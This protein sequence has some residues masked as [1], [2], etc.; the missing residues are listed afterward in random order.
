MGLVVATTIGLIVWI[1][2]WSLG[3]KGVD[4]FMITVVIVILAATARMLA[5]YLPGNRDA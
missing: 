2:L 5:P 1:V 3:A 4:G